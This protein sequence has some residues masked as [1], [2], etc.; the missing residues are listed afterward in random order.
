M[1]ERATLSVVIPSYN[2]AQWLPSTIESLLTAIAHSPLDA[3][4]LVVDDGSTDDTQ[5]VLAELASRASVRIRSVV[6]PNSGVYE[7]VRRGAIDAVHDRVLIVNSRLLVAPDAFSYL[8]SEVANEGAIETRNGHVATANDVPLVGRFWEVPTHVFWG[9]YL[10]NPKRMEITEANFDTVPKGTGFLVVDRHR[11]LAAY[12]Q[13]GEPGSRFV[14]DDTKLLRAIAAERPILLE[15]EFRATYRPRTTVRKFLAHGF[16]RGTLFVDSYYGTSAVRSLVLW[17]IAVSV[18][19]AVVSVVLSVL[20]GNWLVPGLL[21]ALFVLVVSGLL[22][23]S[24]RNRAP[25]Q[26]VVSFLLYVLPFG[27]VFWAGVVRGL[28]LRP[29]IAG[30]G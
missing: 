21:L 30:N 27:A 17:A 5:A 12:Q 18:P 8:A 24:V 19:I 20:S 1:T 25:W 4:I 22:I 9:S 29:R 10:R 11:L 28:W 15:P 13:V 16:L 7:A 6:I 23:V 3:E 26:A 2:S 14:S